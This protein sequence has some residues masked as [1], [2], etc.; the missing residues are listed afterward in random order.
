GCFERQFPTTARNGRPLAGSRRRAL[1]PTC[2]VTLST[3][4]RRTPQRGCL[5]MVQGTDCAR[6]TATSR[7]TSSRAPPPSTTG[8]HACTPIPHTIRGCGAEPERPLL[9]ERV[10]LALVYYKERST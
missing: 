5:N 10:G 1:R 2:Q 7:G 8:A 6:P 3:W 9:L 4:G